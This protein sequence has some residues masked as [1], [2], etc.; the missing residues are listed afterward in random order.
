M[1][2]TL[3]IKNYWL[4]NLFFTKNRNNWCQSFFF[5]CQ[6]FGSI[7]S[8][9]PPCCTSFKL[10]PRLLVKKHFTYGNRHFSSRNFTDR[11][12]PNSYLVAHCFIDSAM[13]PDLLASLYQKHVDQMSVGQKIFDERMLNLQ[14][15]SSFYLSKSIM[16]LFFRPHVKL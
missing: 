12:F 8:H 3:R 10:V 15:V 2:Y 11:H 13:T 6:T 16:S 14:N 1:I 7:R 4:D 9:F 5:V